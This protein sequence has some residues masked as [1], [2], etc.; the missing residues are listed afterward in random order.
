MRGA[1]ERARTSSRRGSQTGDLPLV[2]AGRTVMRRLGPV[3][4][5]CWRYLN[6]HRIGLVVTLVATLIFFAPLLPRLASYNPGGDAMFNA[7]EIARNQHCILR[8]NCP[9]YLTANIYFPHADTMLY[10]ETQLSPAVVT[11]PLHWITQNPLVAFN[12]ITI[13]SFFLS[14]WC[15]YLLAKRLSKGNEL[16]A[17]LAGLLFEFAPIRL[18]SIDHLGH[19]QNLSIFCLPLAVLL[20]LTY[21]ETTRRQYLVGLLAALL[22]AFFASWV[23]MVFVG[24]ALSVLL[25]GLLLGKVIS[26]QRA[27]VVAA[28][29]GLAALATAPLAIQY[30]KFAHTNHAAFSILDQT[31]YNSSLVDY[32]TPD[33]GTL[34]GKLYYIIRPHVH[35]VA[36]NV[37]SQSFHGFTLYVIVALLLFLGWRWV[38]RKTFD[39]RTYAFMLTLAT[40]AAI[41]FVVS[42][43]PFLKIESTYLYGTLGNEV[44]FTILMPYALVDKFLP[45]LAFIRAVGRASILTLFALC[46]LLAFLPLFLVRTK[47][48]ATKQRW[49]LVGVFVLAVFELMPCYLLPMDHLSYSYNLA[50]PPVYKYIAAH[51][52]IDDIVILRGSDDY[53]GAPIPIARAE[54][55]LWSGYHNRYI[56][57]G[58]SGYEPPVYMQ[59]YIDFINFT[60]SVIPEMHSLHL[61]YVLVDKLL[62]GPTSHKPNL[63][64]DISN[65]FPRLYE[66]Q[67]YDLFKIT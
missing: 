61:R 46:A 8:E 41:G 49:V 56:F 10:S 48:G 44:K 33:A 67:R 39:R 21:I 29:I 30:I 22:Y 4:C 7:W 1:E 23:M 57:N 34:F 54:D 65:S 3:M 12:V 32:T 11:L 13:A 38:K 35:P 55:V 37:D 53:P 14:G 15:M 64:Q 50:I 59:E 16:I 40:I 5:T 62:S 24:V 60:P 19:L 51:K 26:W 43:G 2:V 63:D 52:E 45:Q 42:L 58:Y 36:Y 9:N 47:L 31:V 18:S 17:V 66:D 25:L 6:A 27:T 20:V 28:V